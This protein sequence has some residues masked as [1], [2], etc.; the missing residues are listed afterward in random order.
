[1]SLASALTYDASRSSQVAITEAYSASSGCSNT[2]RTVVHL[3]MPRLCFGHAVVRTPA[4]LLP[5]VVRIGRR[6]L[7]EM[8]LPG[9]DTT[10]SYCAGACLIGRGLDYG[11]TANDL[12]LT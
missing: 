8:P 4:L 1:M 2:P 11:V 9:K 6:C 10:P 5:A 7:V 3:R 12:N